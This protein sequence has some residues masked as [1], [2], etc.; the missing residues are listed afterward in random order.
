MKNYKVRIHFKLFP[1]Y[2][3]FTVASHTLSRDSRHIE[4]CL[5]NGDIVAYTLS[6]IRKI[7]FD[8]NYRK[9]TQSNNRVMV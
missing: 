5:E 7:S 8:K 6:V 2:R 4:L 3:T 1:F 9:M